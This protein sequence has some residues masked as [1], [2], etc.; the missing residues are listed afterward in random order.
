MYAGTGESGTTVDGCRVRAFGPE[1]TIRIDSL[2]NSLPI[3]R[4]LVKV[5]LY[6]REYRV[7]CQALCYTT[8][9]SYSM[10]LPDVVHHSGPPVITSQLKALIGAQTPSC[11]LLL[12]SLVWNGSPLLLRDIPHSRTSVCLRH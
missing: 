9:Y 4:Y 8:Y 12:R 3:R 7:V 11:R 1:T 5:S 10:Y 6:A 2:C